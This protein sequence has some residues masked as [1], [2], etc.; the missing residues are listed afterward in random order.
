MR[1]LLNFI[2]EQR[3]F[4]KGTDY[5]MIVRR[6]SLLKS[7]GLGRLV[8]GRTG[9]CER[10]LCSRALQN[11]PISRRRWDD[12][13]R[14]RLPTHKPVN[15]CRDYR[16]PV[17]K[18]QWRDPVGPCILSRIPVDIK[19]TSWHSYP[20]FLRFLGESFSSLFSTDLHSQSLLFSLQLQN[21]P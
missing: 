20:C 7:S 2:S 15:S 11:S 6:R 4:D 10:W 9:R 14:R 13:R 5:T 16:R 21:G 3:M 19:E 12:G 17:V 18:N 1:N 8:L